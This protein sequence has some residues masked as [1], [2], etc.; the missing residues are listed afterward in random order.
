MKYIG[1][2]QDLSSVIVHTVPGILAAENTS[3]VLWFSHSTC[4]KKTSGHV[5]SPMWLNTVA[6][7]EDTPPCG[8]YFCQSPRTY[9]PVENIC[10]REYQNCALVQSPYVPEGHS[11]S[12]GQPFVAEHRGKAREHTPL[13]RIF[14][15]TVFFQPR[16]LQDSLRKRGGPQYSTYS[17]SSI[18]SPLSTPA[19]PSPENVQK[20]PQR[21]PILIRTAIWCEKELQKIPP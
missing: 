8:G 6:E 14:P 5:D 12:R 17:L 4:Q 18:M 20:L 7:P 3:T 15:K 16:I 9:P 10:C 2:D 11:R 1:E 19:Q 13:W 21:T